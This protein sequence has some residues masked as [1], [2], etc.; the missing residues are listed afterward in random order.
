VQATVQFNSTL[1]GTN[2][3]G[4]AFYV[5]PGDCKT[6]VSLYVDTR[7]DGSVDGPFHAMVYGIGW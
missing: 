2:W 6:S 5:Q 7:S 1:T 3:Q 4:A